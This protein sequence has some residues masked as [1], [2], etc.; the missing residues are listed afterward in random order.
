MRKHRIIFASVATA[1]V[2][3]VTIQPSVSSSAAAGTRS[4][5]ATEPAGSNTIAL[6]AL[7][8]PVPANLSTFIAAPI[9]ATAPALPVPNAVPDTGASIGVW[10]ALRQCESGGDYSIDTG[11]GYYG[12]YQFSVATWNG[13]GYTG[14]PSQAPATMQDQAAR[15]LEARSGWGQ[16]PACASQ[17]GL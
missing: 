9:V 10:S 12:A 14:L 16:W 6:A 13:L 4:A 8:L 2:A 1:A 7:R 17:L 15:Q 3:V 5:Q 11:N